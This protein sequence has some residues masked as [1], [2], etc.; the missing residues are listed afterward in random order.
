[1]S[2]RRNVGRRTTKITYRLLEEKGEQLPTN[3]Q[4]E[5][6]RYKGRVYVVTFDALNR[7]HVACRG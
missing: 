3:G 5:T 4:H 6:Y 2:N 1:M 7:P